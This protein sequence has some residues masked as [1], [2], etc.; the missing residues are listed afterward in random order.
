MRKK[1]GLFKIGVQ[2]LLQSLIQDLNVMFNNDAIN[3]HKIADRF[4]TKKKTICLYRKWNGGKCTQ[5][6]W[7][8]ERL[9]I[10]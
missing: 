4:L 10:Q 3:Q 2:T 6:K 8:A 1:V 7:I 9:K 5:K